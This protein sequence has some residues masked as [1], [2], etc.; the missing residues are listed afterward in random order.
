MPENITKEQ[1]VSWWDRLTFIKNEVQTEIDVTFNPPTALAALNE[2][3]QE[4]KAAV[5]ELART[6]DIKLF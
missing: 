2:K 4:T 5:L 3:L 1:L 6:K